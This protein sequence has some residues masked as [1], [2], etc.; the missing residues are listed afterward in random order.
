MY[1][2]KRHSTHL[3][4]LNFVC[5]KCTKIFQLLM[6]LVFLVT[7]TSIAQPEVVLEAET[8]YVY[9][10]DPDSE[11]VSTNATVSNNQFGTIE[12]MCTRNYIDVV[13]PYNYP[14]NPDD[15]GSI[16]KF[17][18]GPICYNF[19]AD[20]SSTGPTVGI[21]NGA[22]DA[23]FFAYFYPNG[24]TGTSTIEYCFHPVGNIAVG[25]CVQ[26]TYIVEEGTSVLQ[27]STEVADIS[28][29]YPNPITNQGLI[30]F[31]IPAGRT[32]EIIA[33][34][35]TGKAVRRFSSLNSK[36]KVIIGASD[37]APGL[38]FTTLEI[39]G[40]ATVTKRFVVAK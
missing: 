29:V 5:M 12:L 40:T 33:R 19:G 26:I 13:D 16:E 9:L 1:A 37:L 6:G 25:T 7:E 22:T 8:V 2:K 35:L 31:V 36:G 14:Y 27:N 17:C 38:Y 30:D 24:V 11:E 39:D 21:P 32:G 20:D 28:S 18:W 10:D 4:C 34:D 23:S 3:V 15:E